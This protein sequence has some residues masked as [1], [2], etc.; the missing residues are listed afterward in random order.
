MQFNKINVKTLLLAA[1]F[2]IV[3]TIV[4]FFGAVVA[5]DDGGSNA[6]TLP[7][8]YIFVIL[9]FPVL[10]V[11]GMSLIEQYPAIEILGLAV[12]IVI[13]AFLIERLYTWLA[14]KE[15]LKRRRYDRK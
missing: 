8:K 6:I 12:N 11:I 13:Y 2:L 7:L 1:V 15:R 10:P 14:K 3:L 4:S 9:N 5:A